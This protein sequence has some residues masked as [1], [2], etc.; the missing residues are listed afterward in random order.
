[1]YS[2]LKRMVWWVGECKI[3]FK[4]CFGNQIE[5]RQILACEIINYNLKFDQ[6]F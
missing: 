4:D 1:M 3:Y 6:L 5:I 2:T